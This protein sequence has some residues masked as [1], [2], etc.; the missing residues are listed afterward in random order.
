MQSGEY[1]EE[2]IKL[3]LA[4]VC[5][6][7]TDD[8]HVPQEAD[9]LCLKDV[10]ESYSEAEKEHQLKKEV[11]DD[12]E[13]LIQKGEEEDK[14]EPDKKMKKETPKAKEELEEDGINEREK[15]IQSEKEA[16]DGGMEM[17]TLN[18]THTQDEATSSV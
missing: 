7:D 14:Q 11:L 18:K 2:V 12:E 13:R 17:T 4:K 9:D 10:A 6:I 5:G 3:D 1:N 16:E 8:D 15:L